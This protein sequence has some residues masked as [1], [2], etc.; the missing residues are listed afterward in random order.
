MR[1][2]SSSFRLTGR[3]LAAAAL[4]ASGCATAMCAQQTGATGKALATNDHVALPSA[5]L[6]SARLDLT[7][8]LTFSSSV[9]SQADQVELAG[10]D[11]KSLA[12]GSAQPPPRRRYGR[13]RYNDNAHNPDGSPKYAFAVGAGLAQ[14]IGNTYH[15]LTPSY[16]FQVSAGRNFNEHVGVAA[17]FDYDNFGFNGRT[18]GSQQSLYNLGCT[19][20]L[21]NAG[22]CT[23]ITNLDGSTHVWS[24]TLNPSYNFYSGAGL[25]AYVIGGA[26][27]YHKV[28]TFTV[29]QTAYQQDYFGNV[30]SFQVNQTVEHYTSNAPGFSGGFGLTFKPSRFASQRIYAEARYVYVLNSQ[31]QGVTL[32]N[33]GTTTYTGNNA[34]PANSNRTS[35]IPIKVGIRF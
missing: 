17:Q 26:G 8:G 25:G 30:Y 1:I 21:V 14:P 15:Y 3:S 28:A 18:L 23:I 20:A 19:P 29:P 11:F 6:P 33:V 2:T 10:L 4:L 22:V 31:R 12:L 13:P 7:E 16:D 24:I 5:N 9:S 27:F 32:A 34:Y 35:Y